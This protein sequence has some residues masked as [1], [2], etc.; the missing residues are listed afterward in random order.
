MN[1]NVRNAISREAV[2]VSAKGGEIDFVLD[3]EVLLSVAIPPGRIP[4]V[5]YLDLCPDGAVIEISAGLVVMEP[6]RTPIAPMGFGE[7]AR[8]SGANPDFQPTSASRLEKQMR[9]QMAQMQADDARREA[10]LKQALALIEMPKA[11][12]A[13][14]S[15]APAPGAAPSPAPA[16]AAEEKLVE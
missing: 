9:V 16:P 3:G 13:A 10:R 14:P 11:P 4:A 8:Q 1:A 15:P 2:F 12:E 7:Q 6:R 5:D